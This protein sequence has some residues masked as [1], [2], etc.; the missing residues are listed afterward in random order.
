MTFEKAEQEFQIRYY[1]WAT[2][3]FEKEIDESFPNLRLFKSGS[4]WT[5]YRFM[6][7]LDR[8]DQLS[9]AH[10]RLKKFHPEAV[11]VLD[12]SCSA[13]EESLRTRL[14]AF[15]L[16]ENG[17]QFFTSKPSGEK[18]KFASKSKLRRDI[19]N[20]FKT[21][22]GSECLDLACV[23]LDPELDFKMKCC[24]WILKTHFEFNGRDRQIHYWHSI[25]E[26]DYGQRNLSSTTNE[27]HGRAAMEIGG[28]FI[29]FNSWFGI[30][31]QTQWSNLMD[32]DIEIA[33]NTTI[34][35][36]SRFSEVAPKLLKGLEFEK[37][38]LE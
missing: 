22:F 36:C 1:L 23:G 11:K 20:Q 15:R 33:C 8:S 6:Q 30:S 4:T 17:K 38:T 13:E 25:L 12:E 2:S 32:E 16:V 28:P 9:L 27:P 24:G 21:A 18:I 10:S 37:I 7:Q 29:S 14:D 31:S 35:F 26:K 5:M 19:L 34:K 3:E